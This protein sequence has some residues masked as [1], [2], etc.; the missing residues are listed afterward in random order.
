MQSDTVGWMG[1]IGTAFSMTKNTDKIFGAN[2]KIHLQYKTSN[3]KGLWLLLGNI[4]FLKINNNRFVSDGLAHIR[5]NRKINE[6]L[7]WEIFGQVQNNMITQ[8]DSRLLFGTGPRFR[9][10]KNKLFRLYA[11]TLLMYE[12]EKERTTPVIT[13]ND[14]R[15]SSYISFT[16]TPKDYLGL[17]SSTYF[18]PLMKNFSDYRVS[19]QLTFNIKATP[20]F[21]VSLEWDYLYDRFPA[22]K[23]PATTY[24]FSTGL[25]YN[26]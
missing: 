18:Q 8:I 9:I 5:Y 11:A 1:S 10:V 4:G 13:H 17:T 23:A 2:A 6:W 24:H 20:H 14:L 22:G 15:N 16:W 7:R 12:N 21:S 3:D 25:N 26:L 19:N